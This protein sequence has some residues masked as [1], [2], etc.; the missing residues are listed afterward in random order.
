MGIINDQIRRATVRI[1][2]V[3]LG[4]LEHSSGNGGDYDRRE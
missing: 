1:Q 2:C 4:M 3:V